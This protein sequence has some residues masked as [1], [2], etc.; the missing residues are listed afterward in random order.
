MEIYL[1]KENDPGLYV[2]VIETKMDEPMVMET[3]AANATY[4]QARERAMRQAAKANVTRVAIARLGYSIGHPGLV[5]AW[6]QDG[7]G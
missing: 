5:P 4:E 3:M 7:E 6:Q 2:V 1:P